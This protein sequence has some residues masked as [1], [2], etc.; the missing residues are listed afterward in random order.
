[1]F[2]F[3]FKDSNAALQ[4]VD[5]NSCLKM[6]LELEFC[7]LESLPLTMLFSP[8][9]GS[10]V[11]PTGVNKTSCLDGLALVSESTMSSYCLSKRTG[12]WLWPWQLNQVTCWGELRKEAEVNTDVLILLK[13]LVA[14]LCSC[15]QISVDNPRAQNW[16]NCGSWM[17][18]QPNVTC[19]FPTKG[20]CID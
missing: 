7:S 10:R 19:I 9:P 11:S 18:G 13:C 4:M 1:M 15:S 2:K 17:G 20:T 12:L 16:G 3:Y 8:W 5:K 6:L 14:C